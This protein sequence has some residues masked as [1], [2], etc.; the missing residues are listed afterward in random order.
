MFMFLLKLFKLLPIPTTFVKNVLG[1]LQS[2]LINTRVLASP[3][4]CHCMYSI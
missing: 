4:L 3:Y 1:L 2:N